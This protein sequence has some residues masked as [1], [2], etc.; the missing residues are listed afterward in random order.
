M[1]QSLLRPGDD[2]WEDVEELGSSH[3]VPPWAS[4][5]LTGVD[6]MRNN[7]YNKGLAFTKEERDKLFLR[8]LLP[9]AVLG[10][11]IQADRVLTNIRAQRGDVERVSYLL[12]LA[13]RNERLFHFLL[14][15]HLSELLPLLQHPTIARYCDR[16]SLMF[17]SLPRGM[18]VGL[19]DAGQVASLLQN[20]PM[21]RVKLVSLTDGADLGTRGDWGVQSIAVPLSRMALL[22]AAGGPARLL[23]EEL[24]AAVRR[25]FGNSVFV[26]AADMEYATAAELV[27]NHRASMPVY[28]DAIHGLPATVLAGLYAALPATG[29][30]LS[31]QRF[32]LVGE[33]P[34]LAA[35]AELLEEA[36]QREHRSGTV[37]EARRAIWMVDGKGLLVRD[38]ESDVYEVADHL[39]P[40]I[41]D[42]EPADTLL[43]AVRAVKPTVLI[44]LSKARPP[45]W[46]FGQE[47]VREMARHCPRPVIM[48]LSQ[49]D[50]DGIAG[51]AEVSAADAW[52]WSDGRAL[53]ADALPKSAPGVPLP[54]ALEGESE[55]F[56]PRPANVAWVFPGLCHGVFLARS[57]R[58]REDMLLA[59]ARAV[60]EAVTDE[61]RAAGALYP[62]LT[63]LREVAVNVAASV[64]TIAYHSGVATNLPQPLDL[65]AK[66]EATMHDPTYRR[67][68]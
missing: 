60:A 33:D 35:V 43:D 46:A 52:E 28:A 25:R 1:A 36:V 12:A 9:A 32:L 67:Y 23:R 2:D 38:R 31:S 68:S 14:R 54:P 56:E 6:L 21:R 48:P 42:D 22:T 61:D 59:A 51:F 53:F 17:R 57:T 20:W 3:A 29:G 15:R 19:D 37:W 24:L 50:A 34:E 8:G 27:V 30:S 13:E 64:A 47:V 62:P 65:H 40:Y 55:A 44:G 39:L 41:Q 63:L 18:F 5:V 66:A 10:Q 49:R 16:Y 45:A 11:D 7:K 58:L 26:D 4:T